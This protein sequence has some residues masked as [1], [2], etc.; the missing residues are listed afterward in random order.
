MSG[1]AQ[2]LGEMLCRILCQVSTMLR[3]T[4]ADLPDLPL[5]GSESPP[6]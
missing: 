2:K 6:N 4:G 5:D 1:P 3:S